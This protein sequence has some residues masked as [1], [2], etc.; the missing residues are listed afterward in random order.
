MNNKNTVKHIASFMALA[1]ICMACVSCTG[2]IPDDG[3]RVPE[4]SRVT[5]SSTASS[6]GTEAEATTKALDNAVGTRKNAANVGDTVEYTFESVV[7]GNAVV[8]LTLNSVVRGADA[9]KI[10]SDANM[11]NSEAPDGK[12]Y[13]IAEFTVANVKDLSGEDAA[14]HVNTAQFSFSDSTFAKESQLNFVTLDAE[15]SAELYEGASTTGVVV[16]V[17]DKDDACYAI[18]NDAV[19]F[20]LGS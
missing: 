10:I 9:W 8:R 6:D 3:S 4:N 16:L 11:F 5:V 18:F 1:L 14:I 12:E 15:L 7:Y 19:W 17:S 2:S 20:A 13:I